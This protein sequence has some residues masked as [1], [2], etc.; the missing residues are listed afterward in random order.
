MA[1]LLTRGEVLTSRKCE[2][3]FGIT[4]DTAARDFALLVK[5]GIAQKH[6]K[7]RS[8]FYSFAQS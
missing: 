8:V 7:G 2:K 1:E 6:G 4:R 3:E 5:L